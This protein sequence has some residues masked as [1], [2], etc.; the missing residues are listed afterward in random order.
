MGDEDPLRPRGADRLVQAAPVGM[1]GDD[2]AT[3]GDHLPEGAFY[4]VGGI[5]EV[6]AKAEKMAAQAA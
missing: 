4:M 6:I 5:K 2:E 1:V 3:V